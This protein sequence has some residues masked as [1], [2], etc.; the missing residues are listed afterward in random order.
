MSAVKRLR[1]YRDEA[2]NVAVKSFNF[3]KL[4][5]GENIVADF[6]LK[7]VGFVAVDNLQLKVVPDDKRITII[8]NTPSKV[9]RFGSQE[10]YF[11]QVNIRAKESAKWGKTA[12]TI[13]VEADISEESG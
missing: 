3:G 4:R 10:T 2:C 8:L 13:N 11:G 1:F 5:G 7:N 12:F 6:Y 9:R